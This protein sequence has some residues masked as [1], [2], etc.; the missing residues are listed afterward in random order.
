MNKII[1]TIILRSA[2]G[3]GARLGAFTPGADA[4]GFS[5]ISFDRRFP[6]IG[7]SA[8]KVQIPADT[9]CRA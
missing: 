7:S 8:S 5:S 2:L 6:G 4:G 3:R 1:R 9:S